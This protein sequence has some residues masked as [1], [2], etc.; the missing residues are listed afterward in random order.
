M[1][2]AIL[3]HCKN[4]TD[5]DDKPRRAVREEPRRRRWPP[6]TRKQAAKPKRNGQ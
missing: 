2:A 4:L 6:V 1:D 5:P 3:S